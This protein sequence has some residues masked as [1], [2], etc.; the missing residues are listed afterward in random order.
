MLASARGDAPPA[1]VL[2]RTDPRV[3]SPS[4]GIELARIPGVPQALHP[5]P[6]CPETLHRELPVA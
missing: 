2:D 3:L 6:S 5:S 4:W 1:S